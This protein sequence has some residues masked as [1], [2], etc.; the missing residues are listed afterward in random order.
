MSNTPFEHPDEPGKPP[1]TGIDP[2]HSLH[3]LSL[4][5]SGPDEVRD[6]LL[7]GDRF[8]WPPRLIRMFEGAIQP[9]HPYSAKRTS[10]QGL[11][12]TRFTASIN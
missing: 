10:I 12:L 1:L 5:P 11:M 2:R 4:L 6:R 8:E 9:G 3:H 7:R